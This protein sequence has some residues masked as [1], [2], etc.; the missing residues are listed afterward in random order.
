VTTPSAKPDQK[1]WQQYRRQGSGQGQGTLKWKLLEP[2]WGGQLDEDELEFIKGPLMQDAPLR[3]WWGMP[4][5]WKRIPEEAVRR[6]AVEGNPDNQGHNRRLARRRKQSPA[7]A[8]MAL[9]WP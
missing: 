9:P 7:A 1:P 5:S 8:Q 4:P 6:I 3:L 2:G